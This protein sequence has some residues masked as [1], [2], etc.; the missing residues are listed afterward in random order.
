MFISVVY[1]VLCSEKSSSNGKEKK[2]VLFV[3]VFEEFEKMVSSILAKCVCILT[4]LK[5]VFK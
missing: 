2:K 5:K 3:S 4:K 1:D